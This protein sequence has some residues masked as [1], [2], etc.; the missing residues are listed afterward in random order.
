MGYRVSGAVYYFRE[1]VAMIHRYSTISDYYR[2]PTLHRLKHVDK[3]IPEDTKSTALLFGTALH[4]G[5][6]GYFEGVDG[7]EIFTAV[8]R[9]HQH[10]KGLRYYGRSTWESLLDD[11]EVLLSRFKRLHFK[12][13][14]PELIERKHEVTLNGHS[15]P[16]RLRGTVD[17]AGLYKGKKSI[18]DWKTASRV[19]PKDEIIRKEQLLVYHK[20]AQDLGFEAD[21]VVYVVFVKSPAGPRIQVVEREIT[22][23]EVDKE[24][25]NVYDVCCEIETR[26]NGGMPTIK[27]K[28]S[29]LRGEYRC[30]GWQH[31]YKGK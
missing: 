9:T 5:I 26:A 23:K 22:K 30:D 28:E 25:E 20:L 3:A 2:C 4:A 6:E 31:C 7:A 27:N 19:Y 14:E 11:G 10:K 15:G 16:V 18:V 13:F 17:W 29:C 24:L 12:H 8:W 1:E 21:Q